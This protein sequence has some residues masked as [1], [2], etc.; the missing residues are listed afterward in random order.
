MKPI[1][2]LLFLLC[3]SPLAQ[4]QTDHCDK[5]S[6]LLDKAKTLWAQKK[7]E[8]AFAKLSAAREACPS[9][10]AEVDEQYTI[11]IRDIANKYE[12]ADV[13]T[14]EAKREAERAKNAT[15]LARKKRRPFRLHRPPRLRR[16]PGLQKHHRPARRRPNI[17]ISA[18]GVCP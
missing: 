10:A 6:A 15:D 5:F 16:R 4:A 7:F 17:C 3:C 8:D 12:T 2:L 14:R 18:G 9:K 11:F 13:K 1:A